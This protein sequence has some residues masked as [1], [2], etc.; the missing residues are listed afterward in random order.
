MQEI[1]GIQGVHGISQQ[2]YSN[3]GALEFCSELRNPTEVTRLPPPLRS[4]GKTLIDRKAIP[5]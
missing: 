1:H 3:P 4:G 5:D 2:Q